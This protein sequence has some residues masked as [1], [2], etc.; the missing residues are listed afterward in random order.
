MITFI[1]LFLAVYPLSSHD[2]W[3]FGSYLAWSSCL[4]GLGAIGFLAM[5]SLA[6]QNDV[7]FDISSTSLVMMRIVL[8]GLF[9]F[10]LSLPL[11]YPYFWDFAHWVRQPSATDKSTGAWALYLLV[12]FLL[13]FS[14]TLVM[15]VVN[16]LISGVETIFGIE[17]NTPR[18]PP[19]K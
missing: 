9:G 5:N 10:I 15:A 18:Q 8:G 7:T 1:A 16:R 12:P 19:T 13:G 6:I 11:C 2:G 4:G 3:V 14:T 17:R